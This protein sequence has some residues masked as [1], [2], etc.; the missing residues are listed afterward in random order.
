M[1]EHN[2]SNPSGFSHVFGGGFY[3]F[4]IIVYL[5]FRLHIIYL[6]RFQSTCYRPVY[7]PLSN[8]I[9]VY[10]RLLRLSIHMF[11]YLYRPA[12]SLY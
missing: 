10:L 9:S 5:D 8:T 7:L 4:F 11:I 12:L 6:F 3:L 2:L 1:E